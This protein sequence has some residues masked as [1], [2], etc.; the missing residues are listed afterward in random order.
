MHT[1]SANKILPLA[2]GL[3]TAVI[4][5]S[6]SFSVIVQGLR[7]VGASPAQ[8]ASGLLA[9]SVVMGLCSICLLYTSPSPRDS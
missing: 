1:Q 8:A 9:L 7:G 3:L 4:A 5:F 2:A 6:S